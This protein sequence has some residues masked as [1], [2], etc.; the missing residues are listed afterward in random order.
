LIAGY[1]AK[2]YDDS[3][4][5]KSTK[6]VLLDQNGQFKTET[7]YKSLQIIDANF[8]GAWTGKS[9]M[10]VIDSKGNDVLG[11][12][13]EEVY[14]YE[15]YLYKIKVNDKH[16]FLDL[17]DPSY[18]SK[19]YDQLQCVKE[20]RIGV[21]NDK[22]WGFID[23]KTFREILPTVAEQIICFQ[24]G[25]ACYKQSNKWIVIDSLGKRISNDLFSNVQLL[26]NGFVKVEINGKYGIINR[27]GKYVVPVMF[28][29]MKFV[30][31]HEGKSF[32][33]VRKGDKYGIINLKNELIYPFIFESCVEL[34]YH[35]SVA[36]GRKDGYYAF[37]TIRNRRTVEYYSLNF[38]SAKDQIKIQPNP[39]SGF[40]VFEEKC[41][42]NPNGKCFGVINWDGIQIIP[43]VYAQIKD[44][45]FN[46]FE[47]AAKKGLGLADTNGRIIIP[48]VY[49]YMYELSGDSTLLQVGRHQGTWG[50][51]ARNGQRLADTIYGG[52]EKPIFS[53]I[54]FYA[55]FNHRVE[56]DSWVRDPTKIGFMN[57]NGDI[58]IPALY[59]RYYVDSPKKGLIRLIY[60][61]QSCIIN[62]E[63][64]LIEGNFSEV[65]QIDKPMDDGFGV[66]EKSLKKMRR[67]KRYKKKI[68]WL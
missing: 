10:Q 60:Q 20:N 7:V 49:K 66:S 47:I 24:N 26:E 29:E 48:P 6:W 51:Y 31:H 54:P 61:D 58:V 9:K 38:D 68:S 27:T 32:I 50:L 41:S 42:H 62:G 22:L 46:T 12:E 25:L 39:S 56:N 36:I 55:N 13:V 28:D 52:F 64:E 5:K 45:R 21:Q 63:G 53:L 59:D 33:G 14:K 11:Y 34:T 30:I 18:I 23:A 3:N 19:K 4:L 16:Q 65:I 35:A 43:P 2:V 17:H 15:D 40:S 1:D 57:R 67:T 44:L 8:L 37:L